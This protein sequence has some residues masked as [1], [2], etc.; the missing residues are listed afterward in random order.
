MIRSRLTAQDRADFLIDGEVG[1]VM[2]AELS[3]NQADR[4]SILF[5]PSALPVIDLFRAFGSFDEVYGTELIDHLEASLGKHVGTETAKSIVS[6]VLLFSFALKRK[7][8]IPLSFRAIASRPGTRD[9]YA[10][11]TLVSAAGKSDHLL[12]TQAV[13]ALGVAGADPLMSLAADISK[14]L[15]ALPFKSTFLDQGAFS[16]IM[17]IGPEMSEAERAQF[18]ETYSKFNFTL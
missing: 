14:S 2:E 12:A 13:S 11:M 6:D 9:E 10:L 8:D 7:R 15:N 17:G 18:S 16:A 5:A 4:I 1:S 3:L